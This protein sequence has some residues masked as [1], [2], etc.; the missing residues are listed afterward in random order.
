MVDNKKYRYKMYLDAVAF[1]V[2]QRIR[3][4]LED[5]SPSTTLEERGSELAPFSDSILTDEV[6]IGE[7]LVIPASLFDGKTNG[8]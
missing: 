1:V 7:L 3:R 8:S 6:Y 5:Y 4:S 2:Y